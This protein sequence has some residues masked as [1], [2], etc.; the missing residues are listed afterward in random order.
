M[1]ALG[2]VHKLLTR[3]RPFFRLRFTPP[4]FVT[5]RFD[6][7]QCI[8]EFPFENHKKKVKF[9]MSKVQ[10]KSQI[11]HWTFISAYMC[12]PGP[13]LGF[14]GPNLVVSSNLASVRSGRVGLG[15]YGPGLV[16]RVWARNSR[17]RVARTNPSSDSDS[18]QNFGSYRVFGGE[19]W[20]LCAE[21]RA[22]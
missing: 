4:P 7:F 6:H 17:L 20:Y 15:S 11:N 21:L 16:F 10:K 14:L 9:A 18:T 13:S 2:V 22:W 1:S 19:I 3:D 12:D 5:Q 8:L